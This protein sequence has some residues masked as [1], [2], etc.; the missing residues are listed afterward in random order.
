M[1]RYLQENKEIVF[2]DL[3]NFKFEYELKEPGPNRILYVAEAFRRNYSIQDVYNISKID[4]WFLENIYELIK[5]ELKNDYFQK[6]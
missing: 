6:Q 4:F 3:D 2:K 1:F 5:I